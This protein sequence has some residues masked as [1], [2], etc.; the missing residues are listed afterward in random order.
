MLTIVRNHRHLKW[1]TVIAIIVCS[2]FMV[3]QREMGHHTEV[4][5]RYSVVL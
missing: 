3:Q 4:I 5:M 2:Q 1:R